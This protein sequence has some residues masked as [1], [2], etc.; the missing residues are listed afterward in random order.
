MQI[1]EVIA[2]RVKGAAS[3][4]PAL[5]GIC[6]RASSGKTTLTGRLAQELGARGVPAVAYS[7]DWRFALDSPARRQWLEAKWRAGYDAY[8]Q[9]LSQFGWWDFERILDD[10]DRLLSGKPVEVRD[11][12]DRGTGAKDRRIELP[13]V[14]EGA[15]LYENGILGGEEIL[16]RMDVVVLLNTA[17]RVCLERTLRRDADRRPAAEVA[18]RFLITSYSENV[19][20]RHLLRGHRSRILPCD[21][22]GALGEFP[23][24]LP[25]SHIPVPLLESQS[26][27]PGRGAVFLDLDGTIV[28]HVPVPSA[29]GEEIEVLPGSAEKVAELRRSG[30]AIV[31]TTSRPMAKAF[32]ILE[33]L[34][35]HGL[36][37]DQIVCDL[38]VG[39]RHV[40]N[41][42]KDD[43]ARAFA[44]A[45]PRDRGIAG[46][47]I[48]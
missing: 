4:R 46:L 43:E 2:R 9:A 33:V 7:G 8:L 48:S 12:Y 35:R 31:L 47:E 45:L 32:G 27:P 3:R 20:L 38:P 5:I 40:V 14:S 19:F 26:R 18:A 42:S 16:N 15:V 13:P 10:L 1:A 17:D 22:E 44:H 21:A 11:G 25:V 30:Y 28:R 24:V 34:K 41:D 6:G 39:P 37:F 36:E 23:E 29:T